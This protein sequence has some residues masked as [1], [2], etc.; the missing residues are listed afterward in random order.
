M[1]VELNR[2]EEKFDE[3][4]TETLSGNGVTAVVDGNVAM[5]KT[6]LLRVL[7]ER[8]V[9]M[10]FTVLGA[11]SAPG[12][13][14]RPYGALGNV[15]DISGLVEPFARGHETPTALRTNGATAIARESCRKVA[16]M[17]GHGPVLIAMD[18]IHYADSE[19]LH[20]LCYLA[21]ALRG[22]PL[23][24]VMT[25][26]PSVRDEESQLLRSLCQG[27]NVRRIRADALSVTGVARLLSDVV[28]EVESLSLAPRYH[29]L[30]GGNPLLVNA[31]RRDAR[32]D[33]HPGD[34]SLRQAVLHCI[35]RMGATTVRIARSAAVLDD[36][37]DVAMVSRLSGAG[38]GVTRRA[39]HRLNAMGAFV[40]LR[41]R[42]RPAAAAILDAMPADELGALRF[43]AARL[44]H[45]SGEPAVSVADRLLAAGPLRRPWA[46]PV[47]EQAAARAAA[48]NDIDRAVRYLE[49]AVECGAV[50]RRAYTLRT[51]IAVLRGIVDPAAA[52][53]HFLALK[54]PILAGRV[55]PD[56][57]LRVAR[58]R[59]SSLRIEDATD[60]I[61][62]IVGAADPG[63]LGDEWEATR[64]ILA[65]SYPGALARL[66]SAARSGCPSAGPRHPGAS[67]LV[68]AC[69]VLADVLTGTADSR[70][71]ARAERVLE[72]V[73]SSAAGTPAMVCALLALVYADAL[74]AASRWCDV[75]AVAA[76][77]HADPG[78]AA[79]IPCFRGL[80]AL[81]QGYLDTAVE[82]GEAILAE[83]DGHGWN[84]TVGLILAT[85]VEAH[86][87]AGN[88]RA[89]ADC[90]SR[91]IDTELF[92]TRAGLHYLYARGRHHLAAD[93]THAALADFL[94]CGDRM[95]K[96]G[97]DAPSLVPWRAGAAEAWLRMGQRGRA[98]SLVGE[99]YA[100]VAGAELPRTEG[101]TLR[102]TAAV[103]AVG[104]RPAILERALE[105]LQR[106]G[107]RYESSRVLADLS[108]V[109]RSLGN[110]TK[111][112]TA[113]RRARR[114][115]K[116]CR[117][118][119]A[120]SA[121]H[122][123]EVREPAVL[124]GT[125]RRAEHPGGVETGGPGGDDLAKLSSSERR[126][127]VLAAAG[128]SNREISARLY[129][130][131]STVEQHL[132]RVYRK[133]S[134][135]RREELPVDLAA[136]AM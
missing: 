107:D 106:S 48:A 62:H 1:L 53:A 97:I 121:A 92:E 88:D 63:A 25:W 64:L 100:Q 116:N 36:R 21:Q 55:D 49:F 6:V 111:A 118:P 30:T 65:T 102:C 9:S 43:R 95:V 28:G 18:D 80:I 77:E 56:D 109:H 38:T 122:S 3:I 8:A 42:H 83:A 85:L 90:L 117:V 108:D 124:L 78:R 46:L 119:A 59:L 76:S 31:L 51:R 12:D 45:E 134:I 112:R 52:D 84:D 113:A 10:G 7:K 133:L 27:A 5:G 101:I 26:N 34:D 79:A 14:R 61:R 33:R 96:W 58:A 15:V 69:R 130:T 120:R 132:T 86:T 89:A 13:H 82:L 19:S 70:A 123:P 91:P 115:G 60:M 105:A 94:A 11:A 20:C 40:G 93:R 128:Y 54:A 23:A 68:R 73:E 39:I 32:P 99:Q 50:E 103:R 114:I 16:E 2:T 129:V 67:L 66:G 81:R 71:V 125:G 131:V 17:T 44:L 37:A 135:K 47:L 72:E 24:L 87:A 98:V 4:L 57:A 35:Y 29:R 22:H 104:E 41:F 126:V 75:L 74:D 136:P 110:W 127:A